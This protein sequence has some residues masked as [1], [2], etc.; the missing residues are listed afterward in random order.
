MAHILVMECRL[1]PVASLCCCAETLSRCDE[2]GHSLCATRLV[3]TQSNK[4]PPWHDLTTHEHNRSVY[5]R[6]GR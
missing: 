1:V 4:V 6:R 2:S 5:T 3:S